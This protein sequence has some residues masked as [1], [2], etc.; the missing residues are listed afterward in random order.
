VQDHRE[1]L[2]IEALADAKR[3]A[4][5]LITSGVCNVYEVRELREIID[6]IDAAVREIHEEQGKQE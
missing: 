5:T 6:R 4:D 2:S 1:P 3:A